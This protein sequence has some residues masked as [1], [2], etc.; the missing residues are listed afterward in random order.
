VVVITGAGN[1]IGRGCALRFAMEGARCLNCDIDEEGLRETARVIKEKKGFS[2]NYVFDITDYEQMLASVSSMIEKHGQIHA[3]V[4]SAGIGYEREFVDM[5]PEEWTK[6]IDINLNGVALMTQPILKNMIKHRFGKIINVT[7]QAGKTGRT[8]HT[9]Y[10]ASKFGL[11]GFTQA[12]A[13][14]VAEYSINVNAV[15]P[16]RIVSE[17]IEN[18]L[19]ERVKRGNQSYKEVL[20][21]YRKGIPI[22]RLGRPHDVAALVTF[23]ASEEGS[24]I[25]GQLISTS[26]GRL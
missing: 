17:M 15:C 14:E 2:E 8:L 24:Y 12:L 13:M 26:G 4:H 11:N 19:K 23:L 10:S 7:S 3:L 6:C 20:E 25:T 16:S 22:G 9:H 21:E 1:G 5:M 18:L